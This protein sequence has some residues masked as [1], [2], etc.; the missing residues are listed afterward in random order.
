M[1]AKERRKQ[2]RKLKSL[3]A[4]NA[5]ARLGGIITEIEILDEAPPSQKRAP[6]TFSDGTIEEIPR[7]R[8]ENTDVSDKIF[9]NL[10]QGF[11]KIFDTDETRKLE[12]KK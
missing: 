10:I 3:G 2:R 4:K 7:V 8:A 11:A 6:V 9:T 5:Y 12:R 1:N